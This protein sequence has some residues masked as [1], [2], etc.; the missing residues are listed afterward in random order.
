MNSH[1]WQLFIPY[2]VKYVF[3]ANVMGR[4]THFQCAHACVDACVCLRVSMY[5]D[6]CAHVYVGVGVQLEK[7]SLE[8]PPTSLKQSLSLPE[9]Q[10]LG[11]GVPEIL[12]SLCPQVSDCTYKPLILA[13]WCRFWRSFA[14]TSLCKA[15]ALASEPSAQS[16][17]TCSFPDFMIL[18]LLC[19]SVAKVEGRSPT[20]FL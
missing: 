10:Q 4:Y 18:C 9:T 12:L 16:P 17:D 2:L 11:H 6:A 5:K 15:N 14:G 13:S 20:R 8:V 3:K 1:A 19:R 7:S